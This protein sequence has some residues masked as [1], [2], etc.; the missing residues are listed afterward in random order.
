MILSLMYPSFQW[1]VRPVL[2]SSCIYCYYCK[3][4]IQI[5]R[6]FGCVFL[7]VS[8]GS[9]C[10]LFW[11]GSKI[12]SKFHLLW[13]LF[14]SSCCLECSWAIPSDQKCMIY[15]K[16]R[17]A[18]L[19]LPFLAAG[20]HNVSGWNTGNFLFYLF[21][22]KREAQKEILKQV[23]VKRKILVTW[24]RTGICT[25]IQSDCKRKNWSTAVKGEKHETR[26]KVVR[27]TEGDGSRRMR[28]CG[29]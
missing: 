3:M 27:E 17:K 4:L 18:S 10:C 15:C 28:V 25:L 13:I 6:S 11:V 1:N 14:H 22:F 29:Q 24:D 21:L 12:F 19:E 9:N 16:S 26:Q 8:G 20:S 7:R 2:I 23:W 5:W